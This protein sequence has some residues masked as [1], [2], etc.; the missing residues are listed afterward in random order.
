MSIKDFYLH[1]QVY[2]VFFKLDILGALDIAMISVIISFLF[3]NFFDT[4]GTLIG[5]ANQSNLQKKNGEIENLN[6][7]LKADSSSS[8]FGTLFGCSPVTSYVES[9]SEG[10]GRQDRLNSYSSRDIIFIGYICL[11]N[12]KYSTCL[13]NCWRSFICFNKLMFSE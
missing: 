9:I 8:I 1:H 7:A 2:S 11:T 3:V 12:C 4:T 5:V 6:R 10:S 13:C